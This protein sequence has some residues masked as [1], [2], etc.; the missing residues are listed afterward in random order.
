MF[1]DLGGVSPTSTLTPP[2]DSPPYP[3]GTPSFPAYRL[4]RK[5]GPEQQLEQLEP[6]LRAHSADLAPVPTG[7]PARDLQQAQSQPADRAPS[8]RPGCVSLSPAQTRQGFKIEAVGG[9]RH[10]SPATSRPVGFLWQGGRD[11]PKGSVRGAMQPGAVDVAP[12][13][14]RHSWQHPPMRTVKMTGAQRVR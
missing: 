6:S 5:G 13:L 14:Q 2:G 8:P 7:P 9:S 11:S 4:P 1:P 12:R 3:F 10:G